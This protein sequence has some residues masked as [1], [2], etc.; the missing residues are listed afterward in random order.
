MEL[1]VY[2]R[3]HGAWMIICCIFLDAF[4]EYETTAAPWIIQPSWAVEREF[5]TMYHPAW[6]PIEW[7]PYALIMWFIGHVI[8]WIINK[9]R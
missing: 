6:L 4:L 1:N 5:V 3:T 9:L 8:I 2:Q 7:V